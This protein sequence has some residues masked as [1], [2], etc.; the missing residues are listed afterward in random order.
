MDNVGLDTQR[1][2][3]APISESARLALLGVGLGLA[4]AAVRRVRK[5]T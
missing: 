2:V 3:A 5:R 4:G 1:L